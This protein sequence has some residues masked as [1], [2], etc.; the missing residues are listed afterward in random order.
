LVQERGGAVAAGG[1]IP[2]LSSFS[3]MGTGF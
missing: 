3:G 1:R 2:P